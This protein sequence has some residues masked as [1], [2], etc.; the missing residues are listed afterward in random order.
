M[1][2]GINAHQ[3][4]YS[5]SSSSIHEIWLTEFVSMPIRG[6]I[7]FHNHRI[8]IEAYVLVSMP[9]RGNI[10]FHNMKLYIGTPWIVSMPI[11]GNIHFHIFNAKKAKI[12]Y[13]CPSGAIFIFIRNLVDILTGWKVSMPIRG[14]IHFHGIR[15]RL[16]TGMYQCPSGAIFIFI[17]LP[18]NL[19]IFILS[20]NAH[21]GQYSFS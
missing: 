6:N 8:R 20:I 10:H 11:R 14:N 4:Q 13:Q 9:I 5:F 1:H 21:Q 3:G 12:K 2:G 18:T 7:H 17:W 15:I 19:S 16:R